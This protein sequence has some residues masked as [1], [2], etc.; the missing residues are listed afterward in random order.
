MFFR[1]QTFIYLQRKLQEVI[2]P[3]GFGAFGF[4]FYLSR[5]P[6]KLWRKSGI[7]DIFG[8]SHQVI[9]YLKENSIFL[10]SYWLLS[11]LITLNTYLVN[12]GLACNDIPG[13]VLLVLS[14]LCNCCQLKRSPWK[15]IGM[16]TRRT[17]HLTKENSIK[18]NEKTTWNYQISIIWYYIHPLY[19]WY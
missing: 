2:V 4:I 15:R 17:Q 18:S 6:E 16:F 14:N 1:Y 10:S 7:F 3:W 8:A 5:Y 19:D 13:N 11:F 12:L 9:S